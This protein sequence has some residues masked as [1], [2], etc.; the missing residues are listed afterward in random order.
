MGLIGDN[1]VVFLWRTI[2]RW[3]L[4]FRCR[5]WA[6]ISGVV[7]AVQINEGMYPFVEIRYN[8]KVRDTRCKGTCLHG[9]WYSDSARRFGKEFRGGGKILIRYSQE[10]SQKSY[11]LIE[12]QE[13]G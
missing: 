7:S 12:D 13:V 4:E 3:F 10:N 11:L 1:I 2:W 9:F 6:L 5:D 8:Y